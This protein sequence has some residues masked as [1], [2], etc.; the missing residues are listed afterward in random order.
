[1][2]NLSSRNREAPS[3]DAL[4]KWLELFAVLEMRERGKPLCLM[5][6]ADS[7]S[8]LENTRIYIQEEALRF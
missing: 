2:S 3:P 4:T 6:T 7:T 1:M 5:T 8:F